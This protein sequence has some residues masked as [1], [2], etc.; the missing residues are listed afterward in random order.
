MVLSLDARKKQGILSY[1]YGLF[2]ISVYSLITYTTR[3]IS[4]I[5]PIITIVYLYSFEKLLH[6]T[7]VHQSPLISTNCDDNFPDNVRNPNG[8]KN[9]MSICPMGSVNQPFGRNIKSNSPSLKYGMFDPDP[10]S[11]ATL[12]T[13]KPNHLDEKQYDPSSDRVIEADYLNLFVPAWILFMIT[14]W[15]NHKLNIDEQIDY[16]DLFI[17]KTKVA[18]NEDGIDYYSN[19]S[20]HWWSGSQIYGNNYDEMESIRDPN[21]REYI[22][23]IDGIPVINNGTVPLVGN[24]TNLWF[25]TQCLYILFCKEHNSIVDML[26]SK[27]NWDADKLFNTARLILAALMAKIHTLE[28]TTAIIKGAPNRLAQ[29][30]LW[31]GFAGR[32]I[33]KLIGNTGS[34]LLSGIIGGNRDTQGV[35]FSH[36]EEFA[37]VY[38]F[39]ALMPDTYVIKD[40]KTD[41]VIGKLPLK[42]IVF[43]DNIK[44]INSEYDQVDLL[45]TLGM[46]P[47]SAI[48]PYNYSSF[49]RQ[50]SDNPKID[51][52]V[53]EVIRNRE[54]Q[55]PRF[56]DFRRGIFL[57]PI[58]S[59]EDLTSDPILLAD[60]KRIYDNDI[61]KLDMIIGMQAEKKLPGMVFGETIYTIFILQTPRRLLSDR[62]YTIDYRPEIYTQEGLDYI[63]NNTMS[64]VLMRHHPDIST[65]LEPETN[66]FFKWDVK[67]K[68]IY[69]DIYIKMSYF[70]LCPNKLSFLHLQK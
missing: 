31:N 59:F 38:H 48:V 27:N 26:K 35:N 18:V 20:D 57:D 66:V 61:E 36:S 62:F 29:H 19:D 33:K 67:S 64:T 14:D 42:D 37:V 1:M 23:F 17:P 58:K 21:Q 69:E 30:V 53:N 12:L 46:S 68:K 56:N 15:F 6:I 8:L 5:H 51:L 60:L 65:H 13:R 3:P 28:W 70:I 32:R 11:V 47:T 10:L 4:Y 49:L 43:K 40:H 45:Y 55:I 2:L 7:K 34:F 52:T 54:R 44:K 50:I 25:P 9:N 16:Q 39:H 22:K 24:Q 63:E 41:K